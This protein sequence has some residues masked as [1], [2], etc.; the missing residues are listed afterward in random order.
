[1]KL[2]ANEMMD[3]LDGT[4][5]EAR[6]AQV[7]AHLAADAEDR[8]LIALMR[9][10]MDALHELDEREPVRASDNFWIKVREGLPANPPKR[11]I[12]T[13]V[14]GML[15]P[16]PGLSQSKNRMSLRIA[17]VAVVIVL[18]GVW[19]APQQSI[20]PMQAGSLPPDA[21]AFVRMSTERHNAY[22]SSQPLSGASVGDL[23]SVETGDDDDET[24][25]TTP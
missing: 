18:L 12:W 6:R 5:D 13:Q 22:V 21:E 25:G 17:V 9:V 3:Y 14:A 20:A 2:D 7:E 19:F 23:S 10:S 16:Q 8:E 15:W 1:M 24:G 11:S 4:L